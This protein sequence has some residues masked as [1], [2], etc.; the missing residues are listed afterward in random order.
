MCS[1]VKSPRS[2]WL[3]KVFVAYQRYCSPLLAPRCRYLP[4]CSEYGRLCVMQY[5]NLRGGW[6]AFKRLLRCHP[7]G[8]SGFDPPPSAFRWWG[9]QVPPPDA[10]GC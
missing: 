9:R 1:G 4:S 3:S 5:G 6:L 10:G 8:G 2:P 7:L